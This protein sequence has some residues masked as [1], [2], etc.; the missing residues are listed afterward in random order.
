M[1]DEY[2]VYK[3]RAGEAPR[4]PRELGGP[5]GYELV[6]VRDDAPSAGAGKVRVEKGS[7]DGEDASAA[8]YRALA[9]LS[10]EEAA[11]HLSEFLAKKRMRV[12]G[13]RRHRR[14]SDLSHLAPDPDEADEALRELEED[15]RAAARKV[16]V[17]SMSSDVFDVR[18]AVDAIDEVLEKRA[19]DA[20]P[21]D[22]V[23]AAVSKFLRT[24][25]GKSLYALQVAATQVAKVAA[26]VPLAKVAADA[27]L[28]TFAR[29]IRKRRPELSAEAAYV[30]AMRDHPDVAAMAV[31]G[32]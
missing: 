18:K 1:S 5:W 32:E 8:G 3:R 10:P 22:D 27:A 31:R 11:R 20:F 29:E 30:Q 7:A 9:A 26:D 24:D 2:L 15:P 28:E 16:E 25:E 23:P 6:D 4:D 13:A 21:E 19:R 12:S 17:G 14:A